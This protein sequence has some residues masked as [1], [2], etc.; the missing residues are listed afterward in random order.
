MM[1]IFSS[2]MSHFPAGCQAEFGDQIE[3]GG[4]FM[5]GEAAAAK[6]YDVITGGI[7]S[8]VAQLDL[9]VDHFSELRMRAGGHPRTEHGGVLVEYG[10][11]FFGEHL[12]SGDVN[13][14]LEPSVNDDS[15]RVVTMRQVTGQKPA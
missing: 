13:Y 12:V 10:G 2:T 9:G 6:G 15:A 8:A 3:R 4:H 5:A 14:S 1:M 11:D 7:R